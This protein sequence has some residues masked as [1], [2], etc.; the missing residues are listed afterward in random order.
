MHPGIVRGKLSERRAVFNM[1]VRSHRGGVPMK[2]RVSAVVWALL[3][4]VLVV[5]PVS[6]STLNAL[7]A[8]PDGAL[9]GVANIEEPKEFINALVDSKLFKMAAA[10]EQDMQMAADWL[11]QFPVQSASVVVGL[12]DKGFSLQGA[13]RVD[14]SKKELLQKLAEGKGEEG[15]IDLLINSPVPGALILAPVEGNVYAVVADGVAGVLLSVEGDMVLFG[16][17]P[18]DIEAAK[19]ALA[20]PAKRM[21]MQRRLPQKNFYFFHDNGMAA[22]ELIAQSKGTLEEPVENLFAEIGFGL[23][24]KGFDLSV[25]TNFAKTFGLDKLETEIRP[26]S[27]DDL[28]LVGGGSAWLTMAGRVVMEKKHFDMIREAAEGGD[29][30]AAQVVEVLEQLKVMGLTENA[31]ISILKSVG[32]VLGGE[33]SFSGMPIPGG[34]L[35]T[36]GEKDW[37]ELLL[38]LLEA[39]VKESGGE[40]EPL[41]LPGWQALYVM[42][43]PVDVVLGIRDG[44]ALAGFLSPESLEKAPELSQGAEKLLGG[45]NSMLF[46]LDADV[47]R[48]IVV[49]L[50]DPENPI[51]ALFLADDDDFLEAAPFLFEG[52]KATAGFKGIQ[53]NFSGMER[54]DFA[55]LFDTPNSEIIAALDGLAAKWQEFMQTQEEEEAEE[56]KIEEEAKEAPKS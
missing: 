42:R 21:N 8:W 56:E 50:F 52:L 47:V 3:L 51:A 39:I 53:M 48:R 26:L 41:T 45:N 25:F 5:S 6:A 43:D 9:Y 12:T 18:E 33:S 55:M 14:E 16:F 2:K 19:A 54:L 35:Y 49:Q 40:F 15:D 27:K 4:A 17:G 20:D 11:K 44:I 24:E 29:Q 7:P 10:M 34:Y 1:A 31:L 46:Y 36:S 23:T 37:V 32:I 38:P 30:D 28:F 13:A 22:A